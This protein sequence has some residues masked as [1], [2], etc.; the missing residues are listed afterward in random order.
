MDISIETLLSASATQ[1]GD[2]TSQ[3]ATGRN[4]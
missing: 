1:Y 3:V 4:Y 2:K